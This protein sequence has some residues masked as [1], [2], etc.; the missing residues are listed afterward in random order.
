MTCFQD[1]Q[2]VRDM[3]ENKKYHEKYCKNCAKVVNQMQIGNR[4][5]AIAS[6]RLKAQHYAILLHCTCEHRSGIDKK[7][8]TCPTLQIEQISNC[9]T[10]DT[11]K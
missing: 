4:E 7:S 11:L 5:T 2:N 9:G 6:V 8:K 3:I 1:V 10:D